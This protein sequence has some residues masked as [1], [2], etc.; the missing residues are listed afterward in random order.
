MM[1]TNVHHQYWY[2]FRW[3][4]LPARFHYWLFML[5]SVLTIVALGS[6]LIGS[7][8]KVGDWGWL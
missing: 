3:L 8:L 5:S 7:L 2:L 6:A 4:M 1:A